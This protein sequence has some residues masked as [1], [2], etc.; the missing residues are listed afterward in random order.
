MLL[1]FSEAG[2]RVAVLLE[3]LEVNFS[4]VLTPIVV[5]PADVQ[6]AATICRSFIV[7]ACSQE[8]TSFLLWRDKMMSSYALDVV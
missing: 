6:L 1:S 3:P 8:M 5:R 4:L 2:R 7:H